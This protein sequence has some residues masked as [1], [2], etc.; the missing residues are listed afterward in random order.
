MLSRT[1]DNL[2]WLARNMERAETAARLL[3]VGA[4]ISLLPTE[5]GY[6]NEWDSLL[7][8]DGYNFLNLGYYLERSDATARLMDVKYYVLLPRATYVGSGADNDQWMM[9]LRA[10]SSNRAFHWAYGGEITASMIAYFL[11][12]NAAPDATEATS[13]MRAPTLLQ[14]AHIIGET[15]SQVRMSVD[16]KLATMHQGVTAALIVAG[17]RTGGE[18]RLFLICPAGNF[19][20]ATE[21][22]PFLQIGEHKYGK[23]ILERVMKRSTSLQDG[24]KAV[25]L[26]MDSTLRSNL[27]V[28]MPLD[29]CV[30]ERDACRVTMR[31]R[32]ESGDDRFRT[33]SEA[34]SRTLRDGF[35]RSPS[36]PALTDGRFAEHLTAEIGAIPA[37]KSF[38]S[39]WR[40]QLTTC[41]T[42]KKQDV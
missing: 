40:D 5:L 18:M 10:L 22:T 27:S 8:G 12:L 13:I 2:C 14:V 7:R 16:E 36:E 31:R 11:I 4:R 32:I 37:A 24:Q 3:K 1:A 41:K 29:L 28:G 20:E 19:I 17:Q 23:P 39:G 26:S 42:T 34:W 33:M 6:R 9:L 35:T 25:L 21:D 15:L 38:R 30:I